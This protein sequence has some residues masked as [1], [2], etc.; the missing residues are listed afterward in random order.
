MTADLLTGWPRFF[1][2]C[3]KKTASLCVAT[4]LAICS[5]SLVEKAAFFASDRPARCYSSFIQHERVVTGPPRVV[6]LLQQ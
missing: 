1:I 3:F 2:G 5:A 4:L 6:E